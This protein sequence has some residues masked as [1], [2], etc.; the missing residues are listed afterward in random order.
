MAEINEGSLSDQL[1]ECQ[2]QDDGKKKKRCWVKP[3]RHK[4]EKRRVEQR[5]RM[6]VEKEAKRDAEREEM[7]KID[8]Q[9]IM[10][11]GSIK[12]IKSRSHAAYWSLNVSKTVLPDPEMPFGEAR[13][14]EQLSRK[15]VKLLRW[16]LPSS[17]LVYREN[18]ASVNLHHL[19]HHFQVTPSTVIKAT[20]VIVGKGKR[21][22]IAFEERIVGTERKERRVAAVGGHGFHVPNPQGHKLI[23]KEDVEFFAPLIHATD[24]RE[25]IEECGFLSAMSREGGINF[26]SKRPGGYRPKADVMVTIDARQLLSAIENGL[27]F[28]HNEYSGLVFGVGK[29]KGDGSW[30][31]EIPIKFVTISSM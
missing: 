4:K 26:A 7:A 1:E 28:F 20:A 29:R 6:I 11:I 16:D 3:G 9:R 27:N 21:R 31:L 19:A 2:L 25:K 22:M 24:A 15:L 23:D 5:E 17:G 13:S 14:L 10:A 30:D 12:D 8:K 18:D